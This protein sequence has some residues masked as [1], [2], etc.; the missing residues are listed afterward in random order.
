M[1]LFLMFVL[2]FFLLANASLM[3]PPSDEHLMHGPLIHLDSSP[4]GKA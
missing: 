3:F 4:T 1:E 2:V